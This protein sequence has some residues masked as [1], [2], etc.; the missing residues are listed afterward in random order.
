MNQISVDLKHLDHLDKLDFNI[1]KEALLKSISIFGSN[2]SNINFDV[3]EQNKIIFLIIK[4]K[5]ISQ[6]MT[7]KKAKQLDCIDY[8]DDWS[9]GCDLDTKNLILKFKFI[10]RKSK[11][12]KISETHYIVKLFEMSD[13]TS[14]QEIITKK[15]KV[16]SRF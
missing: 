16:E 1:V 11:T 15:N 8:V 10:S 13:D 4:F 12:L 6:V 7:K 2:S 9:F 14:G 5:N 3:E